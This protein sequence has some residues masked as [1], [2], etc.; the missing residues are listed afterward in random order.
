M[1]GGKYHLSPS[2]IKERADTSKTP[3]Q[4]QSSENMAALGVIISF[5]L[6]RPLVCTGESCSNYNSEYGFA[7]VDHVYRSFFADRLV[8]C[9]MSYSTQPA[10][11]SLYYNLADKTCEFNNDTK[12]FRSNHFVEKS[13]WVYA[14]NPDSGNICWKIILIFLLYPLFSFQNN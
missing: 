11:Q 7:L 4:L 3:L 8:S 9:Y 6:F 13:T 2:A 10:C 12:Y 14:E 5:L 1:A